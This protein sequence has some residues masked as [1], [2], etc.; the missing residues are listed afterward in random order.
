MIT[1]A[2]SKIDPPIIMESNIKVDS[3]FFSSNYSSPLISFDYILIS[4]KILTFACWGSD[5]YKFLSSKSLAS[6]KLRVH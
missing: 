1:M 4:F 5:S 6:Y 3:P 2:K